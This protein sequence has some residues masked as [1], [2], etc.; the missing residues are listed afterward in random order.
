MSAVLYMTRRGH[1]ATLAEKTDHLGGQFALAWQAT[2]KQAMRG[3]LEGLEQEVK[4]S[5]ASLLTNTTVDAAMLRETRPD[6][7]VWATGAS[8]N[9]PDIPGL[10]DQY[11]M[12]ALEFFTGEKKVL[13]PRVLVIG[14]GR[15]GLE[16]AE[17]LGKEG[18]DVVATKRTDPIGSM[19]EVIT[20]NL[21]LKRIE[22]MKN[23]I[24]MP[25]TTVKAFMKNSVDIEQEG[26]R[27]SLEPFQAVILASGM[28]SAQGPD[29]EIRK[30]VPK[31]EVIGDARDVQDIFSAVQAGYQLA[32]RY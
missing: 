9:Q 1:H 30:S 25:H 6:L 8:Q 24:L 5:G 2:G 10:H 29:E 7:L 11:T 21:T 3:G 20:K 18:Y 22:G 4:D 27:M 15:T 26:V 32:L 31:I 16:I 12:T 19:M 14:A 23:V 17:K 13:G 28:V